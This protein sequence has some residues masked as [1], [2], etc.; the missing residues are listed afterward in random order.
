[1]ARSAA[2]ITIPS[3]PGVEVNHYVTYLDE[4]S[5]M[6]EMGWDYCG[7]IAAR[8]NW[9][10]ANAGPWPASELYTLTTM[11]EYSARDPRTPGF[12]DCIMASVLSWS[13]A[14]HTHDACSVQQRQ[15]RRMLRRLACSVESTRGRI[16]MPSAMEVIYILPFSPRDGR[17]RTRDIGALIGSGCFGPPGTGRQKSLCTMP[18]RSPREAEIQVGRTQG[19]RWR[20]RCGG[21]GR[22]L[23]LGV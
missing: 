13:R 19:M 21:L 8:A 20:W 6:T 4:I 12:P 5:R 18:F 14:R 23:E 17:M 22:G 10:C 7:K 2:R 3:G 9:E 11:L 15:T 1:M 16:A